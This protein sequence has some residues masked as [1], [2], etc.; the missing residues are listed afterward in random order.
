MQNFYIH[1]IVFAAI[2]AV[3]ILL[4]AYFFLSPP[5]TM[6]TGVV[7]C[8]NITVWECFL[9]RLSYPNEP[10]NIRNIIYGIIAAVGLTIAGLRSVIASKQAQI[11]KDRRLDERFSK[12]VGMLSNNLDEKSYPSHIGAITELENL[13][14][15]SI[16][17]TQS[18]IEVICSC[19]EWMENYLGKFEI[20]SDAR[21]YANRR[22]TTKTIISGKKNL[23]QERRSQAAL[24]AISNIL[25]KL[26]NNN[27]RDKLER[28][29][30]A[31]KM[32]C[33]IR[34]PN[35]KCNLDKLNL[36]QANLEGADMSN[37]T[38]IHANFSHAKLHNSKLDEAVLNNSNFKCAELK[39]ATLWAAKLREVNLLEAK[40]QYAD[41][42]R[43]DLQ[44][45]VLCNA[46]L[47]KA[48][49]ENANLESA[50][51]NGAALKNAKLDF[52]SLKNTNLE[53]ADLENANLEGAD[54]ENANLESADLENANLEG[55]NLS[56]AKLTGANLKGTILENV[57]YKKVK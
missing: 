18:C 30:F 9:K 14:A 3:G 21:A 34:L 52:S 6:D 17:H 49:L 11:D 4:F 35:E 54:L 23:L 24:N 37:T 5:S 20:D 42:V 10:L 26:S 22:L 44:N 33:G 53:Y 46:I 39:N 27:N 8:D 16:E 7:L 43:T 28:L 38:L 15:Y 13:A 51:F 47:Y 50:N 41:L 29:N 12:A 55:A 48:K 36:S 57:A 1:K 19:N 40:L 31:N 45:A 32:L 25:S 2:A 56:G